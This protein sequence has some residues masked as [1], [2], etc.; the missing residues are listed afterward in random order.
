MTTPKHAATQL[1]DLAD[2]AP[3]LTDAIATLSAPRNAAAPASANG[4]IRDLG[5]LIAPTLDAP[6]Q[7]AT[8]IRTHAQITEWATAWANVAELHY[9]GDPLRAL[10][11]NAPRLAETWADWDAF[12]DDLTILHTR[13]ARMTGHAPRTIGPCPTPGCDDTVTQAQT[14]RGAEG[15]LECPRGHTYKDETTYLEAVRDAD[16]AI[17]QDITDPTIR[18]TISQFL[19]AWPALTKDDIKN[20]TRTRRLI[21][22]DTRPRTLNL[23]TANI[24]ARRLMEGRE[25]R[26]TTKTGD[27]RAIP[28]AALE[29]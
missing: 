14:R 7:G 1:R 24:L 17:L 3:L 9:T 26:D 18:V 12:A 19:H 5:D 2:W 23:A 29:N 28:R 15:P 11:D 10:A 16:R 6:D 4:T 20:W 22:L 27:T 21:L 8:A 25:K 13:I